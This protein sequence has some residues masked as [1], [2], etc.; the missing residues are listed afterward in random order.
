VAGKKGAY[1]M[2]EKL[3]TI[4][5]YCK[6]CRFNKSTDRDMDIE[7]L[8]INPIMNKYPYEKDTD[9]SISL[10]GCDYCSCFEPKKEK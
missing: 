8:C 2:N 5:G 1:K 7:A 3:P 10:N 4:K 6:D 9:D